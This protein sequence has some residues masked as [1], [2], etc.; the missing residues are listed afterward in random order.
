[1]SQF[2]VII[3]GG[4]IV[5]ATTACALGEAGVR[6]ALIEAR[7]PE[8]REEMPRREARVYAI[9]RASEQVFRS[10]EVW[11]AIAAGEALAFTD[12]E[13][14]DAGGSGVIHFDCAELGEPWLGHMI[15][16]RLILSALMEKLQTT[17]TVSLFSPARFQDIRIGDR[18]V[19][20]LLNDGALISASLLIAADGVRSPVRETLGIETRR[21]DYR[22]SSLV[23]L[24]KTA[25]PHRETAWQRF[26]P[27]GPLAFLP[28]STGWSS[29]VWTMPAADIDRVL[30]LDKAAFH[31]ELAAAFDFRLGAIV[32]SGEREAWPLQRLHAEHYV[33][34][35]VAL[36]GD[37]AHAIHP[38]AGQGVNLGLLD[39]AAITQVILDAR[40]RGRDPGSLRVLRRFERWR[41]GDNLLM[42]SAMD[43]INRLFSN[44]MFALSRLRNAGLALVNRLGPA[45]QE[46]MRHAMGL[47]GDLPALASRRGEIS[48]SD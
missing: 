30:N 12:V 27:G 16:P 34:A 37:A 24:V 18:Q 48:S 41:R 9:T 10:L 38:L 46:L 25:Q 42:M 11:D 8:S 19:D 26:L 31:E 1:M 33:T 23:A 28:L 32:D 45:R 15:E 3:I 4:G 39:A 20:V 44:R 14:W 36:V 43:G 7:S 5:G 21:H 6:V 13:V 29:I 47:G 35:R 22:Q 17:G 40:T 2:D